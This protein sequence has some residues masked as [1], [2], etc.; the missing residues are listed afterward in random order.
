MDIRDSFSR[1]KKKIK[2]PFTGRKRKPGKIGADAGG[3]RVDPADSL[4]QPEPHIIA[5][6][7]NNREDNGADEGGLQARSTDQPPQPDESEPVP[8]CG[9]E[10]D[11]Q[12]GEAEVDG[13]E[14]GK[15]HSHPQPDAEAMAEIGPSREGNDAKEAKI[16]G[17]T[18]TPSIL[19]NEK[20]DGM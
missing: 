5:G 17:V 14:A 15:S 1:L 2:R 10:N 9:G 7:S 19:R 18:P 16:E 13:G 6:G 8:A 12:R 3:G 20:P 4:S 11:Q